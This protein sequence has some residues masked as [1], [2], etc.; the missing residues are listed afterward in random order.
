MT[1]TRHR[2]TH[3]YTHT[4]THTHTL[5]AHLDLPVV[6]D[7]VTLCLDHRLPLSLARPAPRLFLC[8]LIMQVDNSSVALDDVIASRFELQLEADFAL[9]VTRPLSSPFFPLPLPPSL[10]H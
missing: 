6:D 10:S 9:K 8:P 1:Q 2:R 7:C 5:L 4:H 3:T